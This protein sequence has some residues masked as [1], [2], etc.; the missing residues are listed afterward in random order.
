[1]G[2]SQ[3]DNG[4]WPD[5]C[6]RAANDNTIF[7]TFK[8]ADTTR[9]TLEHVSEKLGSIYY[10]H[11]LLNEKIK[12]LEKFKV[13]DRYGTPSKVEYPFG[14][15]SPTT[16]RYIKIV[17][18]LSQLSLED[19]D[20]VE[21]GGGYGGQYTVLR[22]YAKPKSYTFVDL[23]RVLK[24]QKRYIEKNNLDDIE[25]NFY[26]SDN[27]PSRTYD[28]VISNYAISECDTDIQDIY[29]S[30]II[31]NSKHGYIIH[32]K[33]RGHAVDTF[34]DLST[35]KVKVTNENPQTNR[36]WDNALLTW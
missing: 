25:L 30:K 16:L 17:S 35:K 4:T 23:P 18:D 8:Q 2:T 24:L 28:L 22:Q 6:E 19:M 5:F 32:N 11:I 21:I 36:Q 31:K 33:F 13:N 27:L 34:I 12:S 15:F 7:D 29:I 20:I 14:S 26:N 3:T 9:T 1:M 10:D